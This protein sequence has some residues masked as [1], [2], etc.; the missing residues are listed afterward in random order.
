MSSFL[1]CVRFAARGDRQARL[2]DHAGKETGFLLLLTLNR[3]RAVARITSVWRAP[4]RNI[5]V[6]LRVAIMMC[7][8][9]SWASTNARAGAQNEQPGWK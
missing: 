1:L 3:H 5:A 8:P 4:F 6:N 7:V 9:S 2:L